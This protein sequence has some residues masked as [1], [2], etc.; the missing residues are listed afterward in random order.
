MGLKSKPAP[1]TIVRFTGVYLKNT[2]QQLGS[3]G[4][5]RFKVL[6]CET[7]KLDFDGRGNCSS[8]TV[9]VDEPHQAALDKTGY[10]DIPDDWRL[11]MKRHVNIANLEILGA[12][13]KA[14]D[15]P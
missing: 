12:K 9:A 15:Y 10:E 5:K 11:K 7:C 1:G 4:S 2:G 13:P 14:E 6:E 3:E 8:S